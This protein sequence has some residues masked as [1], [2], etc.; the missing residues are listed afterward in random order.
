MTEP[1]KYHV[2]YDTGEPGICDAKVKC[3]FGASIV[4]GHYENKA[5]ARAVYE[6]YMINPMSMGARAV[7][8]QYKIHSELLAGKYAI[9]DS[10]GFNDALK[11][12]DAYDYILEAEYEGEMRKNSLEPPVLKKEKAYA[13]DVVPFTEDSTVIG[14][15]NSFEYVEE[16][17]PGLLKKSNI[18]STEWTKRLSD[19]EV[20]AV[21]KYSGDSARYSKN[22][23]AGVDNDDIKHLHSALEKAPRIPNTHVYSGLN[24][25]T[26]DMILGAIKKEGNVFTVNKAIS[27]SLNPAQINGFMENNWDEENPD[28]HIAL[29]IETNE[30][31]VMNVIS[32]SSEEMEVL[33][34]P[35]KYELV[36]ERKDVSFLWDEKHGRTAD[37][38]LR[39]K[40]LDSK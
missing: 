37:R 17:M 26:R 21:R 9:N 2:N 36:K 20:D 7:I 24:M 31:G 1:K 30:G 19:R 11:R 22:M 38:V 18:A 16:H 32:G 35:G 28:E 10:E 13:L 5:D 40:K 14:L 6:E 34:G 12:R 4:V 25:H 15:D 3:P 27:T 23:A 8:D 29:E 33:L 39:L